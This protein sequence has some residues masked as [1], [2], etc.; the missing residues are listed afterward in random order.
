MYSM[1]SMKILISN[2]SCKECGMRANDSCL[3]ERLDNM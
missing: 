2:I 3:L 1:E